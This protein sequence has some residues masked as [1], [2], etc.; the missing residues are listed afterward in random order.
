MNTKNKDQLANAK[1]AN[2]F[3]FGAQPPRAP[4]ISSEAIKNILCAK[5]IQ[6]ERFRSSSHTMLADLHELAEF[7]ICMREK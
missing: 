4:E 7:S 5:V 2:H 1:T 3:F 6:H